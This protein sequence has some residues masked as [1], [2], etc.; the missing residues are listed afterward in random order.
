VLAGMRVGWQPLE[1]LSF[2]LELSAGAPL[3]TS[4]FSVNGL[5]V[6][7][8]T[9]SVIGRLSAGVALHL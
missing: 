2:G 8:E 3:L 5:G 9:P 7:H 1:R 4:V 6:A